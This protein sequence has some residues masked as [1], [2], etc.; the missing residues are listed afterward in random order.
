MTKET[1]KINCDK[2]GEQIVTRS[3]IGLLSRW[4][5][6]QCQLC[7]ASSNEEIELLAKQNGE[8]AIKRRN[9]AKI[10]GVLGR[11]GIPERFKDH[12]FATFKTGTD[13][14]KK[15]LDR[16]QDYAKNF[17]QKLK[18]GTSMILCGK[19]GTGKTHLACSIANEII[20]KGH[21]AVFMNVIKMM[22][23]VKETWSKGSE[24][25][26]QN[27][28]N[29]F[30]TPDLLILD[31]VGVQFGSDA[32]KMILFEVLNERYQNIKPTIL[33]SN[34]L[35]ANLQEFV[36]ERVMDRM[37]ENGGRILQFDWKSNREK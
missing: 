5:D 28:I 34:L 2:H 31:E 37:K 13:E 35:P 33:I 1:V 17:N 32:E 10:K 8:D 29:W 36:G 25:T 4:S 3:W 6:V 26:E 23:Q 27:A 21:S 14:Q 12:S 22:R 20:N 30:L 15:K 18:D 16:C 9:E 11:S 24:T 19:T 7:L